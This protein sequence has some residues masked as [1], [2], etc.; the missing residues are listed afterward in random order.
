MIA[1][2]RMAANPWDITNPYSVVGSILGGLLPYI[3]GSLTS[4]LSSVATLALNPFGVFAPSVSAYNLKDYYNVCTDAEYEE[5]NI[6]VDPFCNPVFGLKPSL[7]D[8]DPEDVIDWMYTN[9]HIDDTGKAKSK[10][11]K[12]FL[13]ECVENIAPI[14]SEDKDKEAEVR[15]EKCIISSKEFEYDEMF[16]IYTIDDSVDMMWRCVMDEEDDACY[17][18][19]N[20]GSSGGFGG[21]KCDS[22]KDCAQK[23]LD[24]PNITFPY[25]GPET[26]LNNIISTG[27]TPSVCSSLGNITLD[28]IM[29][30]ALLQLSDKYAVYIN[31]FNTGHGCDNWQH[32][33]GKA[34]DYNGIKILTG[35]N[36]GKST[37]WGNITFPADVSVLREYITDYMTAINRRSLV[38]LGQIHC[39]GVGGTWGVSS[40][41][42]VNEFGDSCNHLHLDLES[43]ATTYE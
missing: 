27:T 4:N 12:K 22:I 29:L 30:D 16:F 34:I 6:A 18:Q 20:G 31:N 39:A 37:N 23:V 7:L 33:K 17:D 13:K 19:D 40:L 26:D 15:S 14:G 42:N 41:G 2:E 21:Q 28:P 8:I 1:D 35:P 11:Y 3:N 32:P 38:G 9:K 36:A 5:L 25:S 43:G 10:K 24:S